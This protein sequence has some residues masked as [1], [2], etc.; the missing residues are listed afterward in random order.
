MMKRA[1]VIIL[2]LLSVLQINGQNK[3]TNF[4]L[5]GKVYGYARYFYPS[6]EADSINWDKFLIYA[7]EKIENTSSKNLK[8]KLE[9]LFK[10]IAPALKFSSSA[11]PKKYFPNDVFPNDTVVFKSKYFRNKQK[12]KYSKKTI[13]NNIEEKKLKL[14][15]CMNEQIAENLYLYMPLVLLSND[16]GTFPKPK[17][18]DYIKLLKKIN[19]INKDD[20]TLYN[21]IAGVVI[22]WNSIQHFYP[23]RD[24]I[25]KNWDKQLQT[26]ITE[27]L[28]FNTTDTYL[29]ILRKM[30]SQIKDG[31]AN[32]VMQK[33]SPSYFPPID[34]QFIDDTLVI[35]KVSDSLAKILNIS[36]GDK[37]CKINHRSP[38]EVITK[39]KSE[40]SA[41]TNGY[42]NRITKYYILADKKNPILYLS[43]LKAD[44]RVIEV[45]IT[46][47]QSYLT[48]WQTFQKPLPPYQ[49]INDSIIYFNFSTISYSSID[50]ILL[51]LAKGE[52]IICD[53]RNYPKG[54]SERFISHLLAINDTCSNHWKEPTVLSPNYN[55][56]KYGLNTWH[57]KKRE[58]RL[59]NRCV[60]L[61]DNGLISYGESIM[62]T[63]EHYRL[64]TIIGDTTAGTNG[65]VT[66][67][68]LPIANISISYT[69]WHVTKLDGSPFHGVGIIPDILVKP[70]INGIKAG[71][72]EILDKAVE[73]LSK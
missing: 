56:V 48:Y 15:E 63:V 24:F 17:K 14:G 3:I 31:H 29:T 47:S 58:P 66:L 51:N 10:P 21:Q 61:I 16:N 36:L 60:F 30:L 12:K 69:G 1:L 42:A 49:L 38:N 46:K 57:L 35:S 40:I 20:S 28:K 65:N 32:A 50:S 11:F 6:A 55:N 13:E 59:L 37:V 62:S 73:Y 43:L 9:E 53:F 52:K 45:A 71:K 70:T 18:K 22:T 54:Y 44:K 19:A 72:D 27:C 39:Q 26:A 8:V 34:W 5:L 2:F 41:A 64:G 7:L 25:P 67:V 4:E 68:N 23:Y 33:S